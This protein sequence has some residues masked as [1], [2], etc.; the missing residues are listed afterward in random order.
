MVMVTPSISHI[1]RRNRAQAKAA[2]AG[3]SRG[4]RGIIAAALRPWLRVRKRRCDE[5]APEPA[6]WHNVRPRAG[7]AAMTIARLIEG[8]TGTIVTC[9]ANASVR[10]G[11]ALLAERRIGAMPVME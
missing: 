9:D 3:S 11:V 8:R 4:E 10:E 1:S 6:L 2:V 5:L 7:R